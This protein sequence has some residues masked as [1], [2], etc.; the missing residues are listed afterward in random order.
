MI[1]RLEKNTISISEI[2]F[3]YVLGYNK[4]KMLIKIRALKI[5]FFHEENIFRSRKSNSLY[6]C[7]TQI[8]CF[9]VKYFLSIKKKKLI[10]K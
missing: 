3:F 7:Y 10:G 4:W 1:T 9:V 5:N 6:K 2:R 8:I